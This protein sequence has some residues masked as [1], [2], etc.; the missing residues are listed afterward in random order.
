MAILGLQG[1]DDLILQIQQVPPDSSS[2]D[3]GSGG[4]VRGSHV[5][6]RSVRG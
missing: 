2:V 3:N 1:V 6:I 5:I 4:G